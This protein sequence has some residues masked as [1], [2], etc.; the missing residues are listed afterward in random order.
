MVANIGVGQIGTGFMGKCHTLAWKAVG[1]V[2]PDMPAI[3]LAHL[4]EVDADL[5]RRRADVFGFARSTDDW[6]TVVADPPVD[7]G[8][9][10]VTVRI[11]IGGV[12]HAGG[13]AGLDALLERADHA[14]YAAKRAGRDRV[15]FEETVA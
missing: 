12:T 4:A 13:E 1:T 8:D 6:R 15:V 5:A 9:A 10:R 3:T 2:F 7:V 14:L 11:S